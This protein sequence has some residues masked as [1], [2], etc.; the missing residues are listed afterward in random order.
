MS[1]QNIEV[2]VTPT[3]E[4]APHA[5]NEH[6]EAFSVL[7]FGTAGGPMVNLQMARDYLDVIDIGKALDPSNLKV[8]RR[9]VATFTMPSAAAEQ[10]ARSI[11]DTVQNQQK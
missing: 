9:R 11:L 10:L 7:G 2:T 6:V 1:T 4:D 5:I 3:I 8:I